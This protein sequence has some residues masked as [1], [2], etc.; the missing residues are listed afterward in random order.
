MRT[1]VPSACKGMAAWMARGV[2]AQAKRDYV[3]DCV[4]SIDALVSK[5]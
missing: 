1:A 3:E 4:E 2:R 5:L